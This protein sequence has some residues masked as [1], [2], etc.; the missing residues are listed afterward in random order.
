[1]RNIV[2]IAVLVFITTACNVEPRKIDFGKDSCHTCKMILM[3]PTFGA[4]VLTKK[5]K[6]FIFDDVN[7]L[8]EFVH[9]E[10][11]ESDNWKQ[12]LVVD[13]A[14]NENLLDAK[15]AF[16]V[17]SN[18]IKSPMASRVAAFATEHDMKEYRKKYDGVY[19][20][21]GELITQFK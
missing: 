2:T 9:I 21:W 3:D 7:C 1:M 17:L 11:V 4:E 18:N 8:I 6:I 16:Y 12:I 5:G 20:A 14:N 10:G 13:H 15:T 19:L